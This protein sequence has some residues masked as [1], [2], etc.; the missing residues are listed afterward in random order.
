GSGNVYVAGKAGATWGSPVNAFAASYDAFAAKLNSSGVYQWHTF[1]GAN[2]DEGKSVAV[3]GS[4]NVYVAGYSEATWGSPI[5]AYTSSYDTFAAK[6]N[7][8]G[9]RQSHT[10]IGGTGNDYCYAMAVDGSGN[11][12]TAGDSAVTWGSPVNAYTSQDFFAAKLLLIASEPLTQASSV[13]FTSVTTVSGTVNW[14]DGDGTYRIVLV[15]SGS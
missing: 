11:V 4:G 2:D 10:F 13:N 9:V 14:T 3:D 8:S 12:Y 1:M 15:K 7:S 5:D 6:L